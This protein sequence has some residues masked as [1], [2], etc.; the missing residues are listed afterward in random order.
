[1]IVIVLF[2]A[3]LIYI[4]GLLENLTGR[5]LITESTRLSCSVIN[6]FHPYD[7]LSSRIDP[8]V[9][10]GMHFDPEVVDHHK[11]RKRIHLGL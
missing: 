2:T 1:M 4:P 5:S 7:P 9:N 8:L 11:G 6:L 3:V 10:G